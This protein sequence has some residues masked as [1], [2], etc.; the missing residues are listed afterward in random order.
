MAPL[1]H[2]LEGVA[3]LPAAAVALRILLPQLLL[4]KCKCHEW[5]LEQWLNWQL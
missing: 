4:V 2:G 3:V 1:P 5:T